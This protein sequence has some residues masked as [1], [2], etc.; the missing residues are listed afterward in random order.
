MRVNTALFTFGLLFAATG[1]SGSAS[2]QPGTPIP[3]ER[4]PDGTIS[5]DGLRGDWKEVEPLELGGGYAKDGDKSRWQ[6]PPDLLVK[7]RCAHDGKGTYLLLEVDDDQVVRTPRAGRSEDRAELLFKDERGKLRELQIYP[8]SAAV[9]AGQVRWSRPPHAPARLKS[10]VIRLKHGWAAELWIQGGGVPGYGVGSPVLHTTL[11]VT[12]FDSTTF[13]KPDTVLVTGGETPETLGK[14]EYD[15]AK[16][17]YAQF[18]KD[19]GLTQRNVLYYEVGN[20]ITGEALEQLVIAGTWIAFIGEDVMKGGAY[21]AFPVE[22]AKSQS[23]MLRFRTVNLDG[24]TN[25]SILLV[26]RQEGTQGL[27]RDI[28]LILRF[29]DSGKPELLLAM[30]VAVRR[31]QDMV[32][33]NSY[34][35]V[36]KGKKHELEV[37]VDKVQGWTKENHRPSGGQGLEGIL[38]PW[39]KNRRVYTFEADGPREK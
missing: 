32:M 27:S 22:M 8:P 37:T 13:N 25:K 16:K 1:L 9:R 33:T 5:V 39:G 10:T 17:L 21:Y 2:A 3:C 30:E 19:K 20:F 11:R 34:K 12:D 4:V 14:I 35:L 18:L 26:I 6:G 15:T 36:P 7:L 28:M 24:G 38:T 23:D 29:A 31:G